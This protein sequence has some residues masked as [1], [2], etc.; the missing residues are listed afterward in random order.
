MNSEKYQTAVKKIG[1][2]VDHLF[3]EGVGAQELVAALFTLGVAK[4]RRVVDR[5]AVEGTVKEMTD[6]ALKATDPTNHN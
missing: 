5:D 3:H 1:E 6:A 4:I 2:E